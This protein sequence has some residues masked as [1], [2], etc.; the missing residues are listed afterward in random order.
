MMRGSQGW[1]TTLLSIMNH[2]FRHKTCLSFSSM[3]K[4][5][6]CELKMFDR[7]PRIIGPKDGTNIL[8]TSAWR[9][10]WWKWNIVIYSFSHPLIFNPVT[11]SVC[12]TFSISCIKSRQ[13]RWTQISVILLFYNLSTVS[14]MII[15]Y[16]HA[17]AVEWLLYIVP[18]VCDLEIDLSVL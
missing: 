16:L 2:Y 14:F 9:R 17:D 1:G 11:L 12:S 15:I 8:V 4:I 6:R 5:Y 7:I 10:R 3:N 13:W 18:P